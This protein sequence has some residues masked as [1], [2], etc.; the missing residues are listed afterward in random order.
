MARRD[1]W[2][3][4][5]IRSGWRIDSEHYAVTTN[6]SLEEGVRLSRRLESL[7]ALEAEA[8]SLGAAD[9]LRKPVAP[10]VLVLRIDNVTRLAP[11]LARG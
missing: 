2:S 7:Y 4:P 10:E 6:H 9:L 1:S 5:A 3:L 11:A 8:L